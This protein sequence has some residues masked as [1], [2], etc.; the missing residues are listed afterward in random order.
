MR[1]FSLIIPATLAIVFSIAVSAK[2]PTVI[3]EIEMVDVEGGTFTM[4]LDEGET[5]HM[6]ETPKHEVT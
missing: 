1:L 4:G 6:Y 2:E 3:L 5:E